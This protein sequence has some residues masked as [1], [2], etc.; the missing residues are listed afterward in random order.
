MIFSLKT[1]AITFQIQ[2]RFNHQKTKVYN[3]SNATFVIRHITVNNQVLEK[4]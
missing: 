4:N 3:R 2:Q 1:T